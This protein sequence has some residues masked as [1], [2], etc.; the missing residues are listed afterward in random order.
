MSRNILSVSSQVAYGPVG[1]TASVPALHAAGFT[2][3]QVPTIILSHHP[4]LGK[5]AGV[6]LPASEIE[7]LLQSLDAQGATTSCIGAMTGYFA[8]A[9][10]VAI[11]A[12][13]LMKAKQANPAL[14]IL[15]DPVLGD[16]GRLYVGQDVAEAVRADLLPLADMLTPNAFE[17][18]FLSGHEVNTRQDAERAASKLACP[19]ILAKSIDT[20]DGRILTLTITKEGTAEASTPRLGNVPHGTGDFLAG[21]YLASRLNAYAPAQALT[22]STAIL[23]SAIERSRG[24]PTLDVIGALHSLPSS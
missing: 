14:I 24:H 6:R 5:P 10:Q 4:G 2:V 1:N 19:E 20:D 21:L 3:L 8:S 12:R 7:A 23:A 17:L 16:H 15:V 9:D 18:G 13:A 22:L 11:T